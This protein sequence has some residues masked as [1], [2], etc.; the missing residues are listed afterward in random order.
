MSSANQKWRSTHTW[1]FPHK[2]GA[3]ILQMGAHQDGTYLSPDHSIGEDYAKMKAKPCKIAENTLEDPRKTHMERHK[4][5][6]KV[7]TYMEFSY[8][9]HAGAYFLQVGGLSHQDGTPCF[10]QMQGITA[11]VLD[12][13]GV[14]SHFDGTQKFEGV[15]RIPSYTTYFRWGHKRLLHCIYASFCMCHQ[16]ANVYTYLDPKK[17]FVSFLAFSV[18]IWELSN[19]AHARWQMTSNMLFFCWPMWPIAPTARVGTAELPA[20]QREELSKAGYCRSNRSEKGHRHD[21][22]FR[23]RGCEQCLKA[24]VEDFPSWIVY[25]HQPIEVFY[26]VVLCGC[27]SLFHQ[28]NMWILHWYDWIWLNFFFSKVDCLSSCCER[29]K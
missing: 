3:Y 29:F 19:G 1:S 8:T 26:T 16:I 17:G 11:L 15:P 7:K 14:F 4:P 6:V 18:S 5:R 25:N 2:T 28:S 22:G 12:S 27:T 21:K 24:T 23:F 9:R 13:F 20:E 10:Q